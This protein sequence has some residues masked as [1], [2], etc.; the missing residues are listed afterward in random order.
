M[1]E[2][3]G[4]TE[5]FVQHY[6]PDLKEEALEGCSSEQEIRHAI[7]HVIPRRSGKNLIRLGGAMDGGY[8][9]PDDL[10]GIEICFSPGTN[11]FKR[12]EDQIA[13]KYGIKSYMCDFTSDESLFQTQLIPNLQFFEK[14]WLDV[15]GNLDSIDLESWVNTKA[16]PYT[17]LILQMDI[18]GAE[19]RNIIATDLATLA[20]FR[21]IVIE[22]HG[23][24][25]M[26]DR[27]FVNGVFLPAMRKLTTHHTC[28]HAH[29]NN[30]CGSVKLSDDLSVP[31]GLEITLLR[32]DRIHSSGT[33]LSLPHELDELNVNRNPPIH[34]NGMW[35][36]E[37]DEIRSRLNA[38][39]QSV[40]WMLHRMDSLAK[41]NKFLI[42]NSQLQFNVALNKKAS[43]SS[44]SAYSKIDDASGA[45]T[46]AKT[47]H[48]GFHTEIEDDPWWQLD[49]LAPHRLEYG[50]IYNR[51]DGASVRADSLKMFISTDGKLW[52]LVYNH[53]GNKTFGGLS[54][55]DGEPPL[56]IELNGA[57]ARFVKLRL[58]GKTA[59][60][61]DEVEIYG[62]PV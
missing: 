54:F 62:R 24:D 42:S 8:L 19:Y 32:H 12:F 15:Y 23:L 9:V 47:G 36:V 3:F 57:E 37:T 13:H 41:Y 52:K 16:K 50:L 51:M 4:F 43:Q 5:Y 45:I 21:I 28:V 1:F 44:L 59:L 11:N 53:A 61:L 18:E 34:L 49:L 56:L 29:A 7:T 39:E 55:H 26:K 22:L 38:L 46:G 35:M 27:S 33:P 6:L 31:R 58:V 10:D 25:Q 2:A 48:F 40:E 60:H 20:R 14:K 17:D 30:C